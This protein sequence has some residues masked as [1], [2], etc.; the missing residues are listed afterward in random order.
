[1][2][3]RESCM[4]NLKYTDEGKGDT[5]ILL[6]GLM[7]SAKNFDPLISQLKL[8][9]RVIVP[10]YPEYKDARNVTIEHLAEYVALLIETLKIEKFHLLGNSMG[11]HIALLYALKYP[12]KLSSLILSGSS[13]LYEN[14]IGDSYP[15]R[16][17]YQYVEEK[18]KATFYDPSIVSKE[19]I[20]EIFFKINSLS[21]LQ[22]ISLA[23]ST[24][25][26]NLKNEL[27]NISTP[28]C[29]VWGKNDIITPPFVAEV[30]NIHLKNSELN[31][32]ENC[33]HVPMLEK[34]L[35]FYRIIRSFI[36]K[37]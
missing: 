17:D 33:G 5:V 37:Y 13:G 32:I 10:I 9:F 30:F 31:W 2:N 26:N 16:K 8:E 12:Q 21:V 28:V 15:K 7:G 11:G 25:R 35:E 23:K 22:I 27:K 6:Y 24:I 18:V 4:E 29:I 36:D 3:K 20:D 1:M 34:P 19:M 14:G